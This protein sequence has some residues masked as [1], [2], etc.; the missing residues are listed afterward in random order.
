MTKLQPWSFP[1]E[2]RFFLSPFVLLLSSCSP[3]RCPS[4]FVSYEKSWGEFVED[5]LVGWFPDKGPFMPP[6]IN[7][8]SVSTST[9]L[10]NQNIETVI[11][12]FHLSSLLLVHKRFS[13][14]SS[15]SFCFSSLLAAPAHFDVHAGSFF[16][17]RFV[18]FLCL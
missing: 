11:A 2:L 13:F 9:I 16:A 12:N 18:W 1:C 14:V 10:K 5:G 17:G 8:L 4:R 15:F 7:L 6:A 3:L